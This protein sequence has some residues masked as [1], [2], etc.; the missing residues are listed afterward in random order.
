MNNKNIKVGQ[1]LWLKV[2][3]QIDKIAEIEYPMLIA[4]IFDDYIEVI[5]L[6][7][8]KG[9]LHQLYKPYNYYINS[10]S[11]R[12]KVIYEDSY[13]QFN[14]KLTIDWFEDLIKV[15]KTEDTLS[16]EKLNE[17]LISYE[18]YQSNNKLDE[19][20]I[21]HMTIEEIISLNPILRENQ[22]N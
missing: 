3:Y 19:E 16:K 21:V 22:Y 6:D 14:T 18:E 4:K 17:L 20:R 2:R 15:R 7:K 8:T 1:V 10:E 5:A 13:A 9:K 12:E 11:P